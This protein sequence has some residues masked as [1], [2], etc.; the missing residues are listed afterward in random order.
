M[1]M[2]SRK[3]A[4]DLI[5][6]HGYK[7]N[8]CVVM[9]AEHNRKHPDGHELYDDCVSFNDAL[10]AHDQYAVIDVKNWLGY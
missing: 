7:A 10:G 3:Q 8:T 6:S 5:G 4:L 1:R 2:I 9:G